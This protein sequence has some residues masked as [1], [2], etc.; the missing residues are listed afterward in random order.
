MIGIE[1][2]QAAHAELHCIFFSSSLDLYHLVSKTLIEQPGRKCPHVESDVEILHFS[3]D[4]K[5]GNL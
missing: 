2:S 5:V 1:L 3:A 4:D